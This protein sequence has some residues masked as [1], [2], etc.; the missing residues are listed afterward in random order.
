MLVWKNRRVYCT[1][2]FLDP[3]WSG[4]MRLCRILRQGRST[5]SITIGDLLSLLAIRNS[6]ITDLVTTEYFEGRRKTI[7][8]KLLTHKGKRVLCF[9]SSCSL[10]YTKL[11]GSTEIRAF[12]E[13]TPCGIYCTIIFRNWG[14]LIR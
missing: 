7:F 1:L 4:L 14:W 2:F 12:R 3:G 13:K 9:F 6:C 8:S 10:T 11:I 5:D